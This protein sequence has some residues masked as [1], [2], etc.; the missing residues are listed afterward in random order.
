MIFI[1]TNSIFGDGGNDQTCYHCYNWMNY[2]IY[3]RDGIDGKNGNMYIV[4]YILKCR[5]DHDPCECDKNSEMGG[6]FLCDFILGEPIDK[7]MYPERLRV[8]CNLSSSEKTFDDEDEF[9]CIDL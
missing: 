3:S 6:C 1:P 2:S 7:I 5:D 8:S 9:I 4:D